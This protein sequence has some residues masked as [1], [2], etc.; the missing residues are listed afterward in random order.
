MIDQ[1]DADTELDAFDTYQGEA[2][3]YSLYPGMLIYPALG[4]AGEAGEVVEKVKKLVRDDHMPLDEDF[5]TATKLDWEVRRDIA[6]E[7]GDVLWYC[8]ML[9][10]CSHSFWRC[11]RVG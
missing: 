4:L 2:A 11:I 1:C 10:R 5:N 7:I 3:R 8:A 9:A 6:L